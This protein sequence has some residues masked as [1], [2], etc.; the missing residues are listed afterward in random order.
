[1]ASTIIGSIQLNEDRLRKD[2]EIHKAFPLM[3]EEY[4]VFSSGIWQNCSLW[5]ASEDKGD[6]LFQDHGT[7]VKL[8]EYGNALSYIQELVSTHFRFDNLIMVRTRNLID[9][10]VIPHRD[11]VELDKPVEQYYRVFVPLETNEDAL[12]SDQEKVFNMRKGEV[13]HLDAALIHAAANFSNNSRIFLCLDFS[14]DGPFHPKD[15]FRNEEEYQPS[16]MINQLTLSTPDVEL[17]KEL[18]ATFA[19]ILTDYT[20]RDVLF[21]LSKIHFEQQ[22]PIRAGYD[23]LVEAAQLTGD[24]KLYEK[25]QSVRDFL[26]HNRA[27]K[28]S[29]TL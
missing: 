15:I 2:L 8:T 28:E 6:T 5:N 14:F 25:A 11:F 7:D 10:M 18:P 1:M 22:I 27:F 12:H 3:K 23:W 24:E 4:D 16:Q 29:L 20:F 19:T 13:W 9:G 17:E 21:L 26:I